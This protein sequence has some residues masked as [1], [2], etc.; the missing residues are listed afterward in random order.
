MYHI[1]EDQ[2]SI[3][4]AKLIYTGL[5][6]LL[7]EDTFEAITITSIVKEAGVGRATFYRN[8]DHKID[9]L[10]YKSDQVFQG[11]IKHLTAY[12]K[13]SPVTRSSEFMLPFLEYF[14]DE[15]E[16]VYQL[17]KANRQDILSDSFS[18][19]LQAM[20]PAYKTIANSP[21]ET[22]EYFV[23]IRSG[24]TINILIQ[25]VKNNQNLPPD[26]LGQLLT[27]QLSRS[28]SVDQFL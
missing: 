1:K 12:H 23:A 19:V 26:Q 11:L 28:F 10:R 24:I 4:S 8:F 13:K 6:K 14:Y 2:R 16:I 25:W 21:N 27:E 20:F 18:I 15:S 3:L 22:W 17:I 5:S 9:I 7:K